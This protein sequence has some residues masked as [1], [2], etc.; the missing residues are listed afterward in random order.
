MNNSGFLLGWLGHF[1][2]HLGLL[3]YVRDKG[4]YLW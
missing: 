4:P 1:D 3:P 2:S